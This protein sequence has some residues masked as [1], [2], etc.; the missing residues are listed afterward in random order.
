VFSV[1]YPGE[2]I[3]WN[4]LAAFVL[5]AAAYLMLLPAAAVQ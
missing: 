2:A 5:I 4:H 1:T 3:R